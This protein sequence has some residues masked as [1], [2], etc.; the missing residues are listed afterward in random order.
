MTMSEFKAWLEGF[1]ASIDKTPTE[2]QWKK[3]KEKL[4]TVSLPRISPIYPTCPPPTAWR[5]LYSG[6]TKSPSDATDASSYGGVC[7]SGSN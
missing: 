3:I 4:D 2:K 6:D 5:T 7:Y 1:E